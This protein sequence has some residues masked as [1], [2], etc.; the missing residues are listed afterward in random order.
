MGVLEDVND[1]KRQGKI[2]KTRTPYIVL[3]MNVS[4]DAVKNGEAKVYTAHES[5]IT[6]FRKN[7]GKK[8]GKRGPNYVTL[9][10]KHLVHPSPSQIVIGIDGT[11]TEQRPIYKMSSQLRSHIQ[12]LVN[13]K[14]FEKR[15]EGINFTPSDCI[16][17]SPEILRQTVANAKRNQQ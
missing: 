17:C 7:V 12:Q 4:M 3:S 8:E 11:G 2:E 16:A 14:T 13:T 5:M 1:G 9:D 10:G 6:S 15:A